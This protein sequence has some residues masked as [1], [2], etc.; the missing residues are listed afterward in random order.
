MGNA[1]TG[2]NYGCVMSPKNPVWYYALINQDGPVSIRIS[3]S[4]NI[5]LDVVCWGPFYSLTAP[6][7]A[8]LTA[9]SP[10][11][12]HAGPGPS[13]NYPSGMMIDCAYTTDSVE[14]IY[15]PNGITGEYYIFMIS[16][17]SNHFGNVIMYQDNIVPGMGATNCSPCCCVLNSIYAN[18]SACDTV[19]NS[20]TISGLL[21]TGL[22]I[23]TDTLFMLDQQ[24]GSLMT[25]LPPVETYTFYD[26]HGIPSD[27]QLHTIQTWFTWDTACHDTFVIQ[28]PVPC[29]SCLVFAGN[30]TTICQG[31]SVFLNASGSLVYQWSQGVSQGQSFAPAT[32]GWYVVSA[33]DS[34]GCFARDSLY[35]TVNSTPMTP[36]VTLSGDTLYASPGTGI[37]W[38]EINYGLLAGA[39]GAYYIPQTDGFY[40]AIAS[41]GEC[42]SDSSNMEYFTHVSVPGLNSSGKISMKPNPASNEVTFRK[43][44]SENVSLTISGVSGTVLM[45]SVFSGHELVLDI[46]SLNSGIYV[47]TIRGNGY[48]REMKLVV[49]D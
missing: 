46:S 14:W 16:N 26:M 9:G 11:P 13:P 23:S 3:S 37:Q 17:Y 21:Y 8:G 41:E 32:S 29:H 27:G 12:S 22:P 39:T 42:F 5:D 25:I 2:P 19:N 10:T 47:V 40:Y 36:V 45:T 28:A 49:T 1:E 4:N 18:V 48:V 35:I 20:C 44:D 30:D 31:D 33:T 6:C 7:T 15:I 38:Y 43:P 24:S 34:T